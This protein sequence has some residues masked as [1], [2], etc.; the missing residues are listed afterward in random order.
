VISLT[1]MAGAS[2]IRFDAAM[3]DLEERD[4]DG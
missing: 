1:L 4:H 3:V 2:V